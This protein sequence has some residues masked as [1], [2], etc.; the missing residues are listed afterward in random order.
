MAMCA[1]AALRSWSMDKITDTPWLTTKEAAEYARVNPHTIYDALRAGDLE[2]YQING[3]P[4]NPWRTTTEALDRWIRGEPQPL[5]KR[6][7]QLTPRREFRP[8]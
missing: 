5:K 2:G 7:P 1:V 4:T 3:K 8:L 6:T